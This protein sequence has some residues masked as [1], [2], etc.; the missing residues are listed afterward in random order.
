MTQGT[1][2]ELGD[3]NRSIPGPSAVL[4]CGF[5]VAEAQEVRALL[6]RAG[7]QTERVI[8]CSEGL[9]RKPLR[10]ALETPGS[11]E[12][13]PPDRLPRVMILSGMTESQIGLFLDTFRSSGLPRPIFATATEWNLER[14]VRQ[15]LLDLVKEHRA[16]A[17]S[18]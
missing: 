6:G 18:K 12:P 2:R 11:E 9:L 13:V 7:I 3:G 5:L 16:L 4:L 10:E 8:L 14:P 15:V 17:G 1:F